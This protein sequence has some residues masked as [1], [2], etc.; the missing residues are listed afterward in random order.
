MDNWDSKLI[1][2]HYKVE[3]SYQFEHGVKT[4]NRRNNYVTRL[5]FALYLYFEIIKNYLIHHKI[6]LWLCL[7]NPMYFFS[8]LFMYFLRYW[9]F[10]ATPANQL[11]TEMFWPITNFWFV[12]NFTKQHLIFLSDKL[13]PG[14]SCSEYV[15]ES[16]KMINYIIVH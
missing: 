10:K 11:Q 5:H 8:H 15:F 16:F 9:R 1:M 12:E 3:V 7:F 14:N 4:D 2:I 13:S 6:N